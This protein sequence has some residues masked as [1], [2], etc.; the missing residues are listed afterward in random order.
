M[1][2]TTR[3]VHASSFYSPANGDYTIVVWGY[4]TAEQTWTD[5]TFNGYTSEPTARDLNACIAAFKRSYTEVA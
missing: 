5:R 1:K 2:H 4:V 3:A